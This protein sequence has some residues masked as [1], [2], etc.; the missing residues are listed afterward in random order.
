M[1]LDIYRLAFAR[2][3][4]LRPDIAREILSRT[5]SEEAFMTLSEGQLRAMLGFDGKI[6]GDAYRNGLLEDA[7]RESQFIEAHGLAC[8]YFTDPAYPRRMLECDDAPLMLFTLGNVDLN[9]THCLSIVGTRNATTYGVSFINR[10]VDELAERMDG[11]LIISGLAVGCDITAHK[12]AMER[13][14]PTAAVV[15]HGLDTIF[16]ADHR[17][18]AARMVR[19]GGIL[20]TEYPSHTRPIRPNFLARNR[21]IAGMSDTVIVAESAPP[22]E[23]HCAPPDWGCSTTA[24]SS[25]CPDAHPTSIA[26]GATL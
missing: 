25:L 4:G 6:L 5:G 17:N 1:S 24:T 10:L 23:E 18:I 16:P 3:K 11:L 12:R 9:A 15:A 21:I 26:A 22:A 7:R 2:V 20:V 13:G 8:S 19:S 14:I